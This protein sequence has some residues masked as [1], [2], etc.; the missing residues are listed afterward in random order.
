MNPTS[1]LLWQP[2]HAFKAHSNLSHFNNWL[3]ENK[4]MHFENYD[5]LWRWSVDSPETFWN[6][7][8]EYFG[9]GWQIADEHVISDDEMPFVNWFGGMD[10]NYAERVFSNRNQSSPALISIKEDGERTELTWQEL[11]AKVGVFQKWLIDQGVQPGDRVAAYMPNTWE[12]TVAFLATCA[13]GG[14][15][16]S[17][18][19][20]FGTPSVVERFSQV[21]P[22]VMLVCNAYRYNGKILDRN[23]EI[24]AIV[25][26]LGSVEKVVQ[27]AYLKEVACNPDFTTWDEVMSG[28]DFKPFFQALS[29]DHPIWVLYSSGTTGK[30][31]S[32]VHS[33]GGVLLEHLKYLA[34]HND[35]KSGERFIWY[36]TT[37]WM[38]WNYLNATLLLGAT[39]VLYD[40]SPSFPDLKRLWQLV[41]REKINHFGTSAGFLMACM[42]S[43]L[44]P[45]R[46]FD[47]GALR[48]IGSTGS[49][50]SPECFEWV[51]NDVKQ[52]VWLTSISGGTD[53]CSAFVGGNPWLPVYE[54]QIQCRAL[55]CK[56]EAW[57]EEGSAV[58]NEV[59]EM[60]ITKAMPSMPL[61]FWGDKEYRNYISSYFDMYPGVWRHGDWIKLTPEGGIVIYGRSDSTL[62]R[63]GVRIGSSEIYRALNAVEGVKDSL[64]VCIDHKDGSQFMPLFVV[65][66]NRLTEKLKT[67]IK[68]VL[69]QQYS[70]RHVPDLI[71]EVSQIPY[72]IS[73][74]KMEKPIKRI[75]SGEEVSKAINIGAM[76]NPES[77]EEYV[78]LKAEIISA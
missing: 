50:L 66:E 78:N 43:G 74:K 27:I 7:L 26:A 9:L 60:V 76:R 67:E 70:P 65:T 39:A 15:W 69:R 71:V 33:Q 75:L 51:Y 47:L 29:F 49:P 8:Q 56:L 55:G 17:C 24:Q 32:I 20:D 1:K 35:V 12:T 23:P 64:V 42:N 30:P 34:F 28:P 16:T 77:V 31:K 3:A 45:A 61:R 72:T 46:E 68:T 10:V 59:G 4:G 62:N 6:Y 53:V 11:E 73:G 5:Y 18:S 58:R 41:E 38:M 52:D 19:P 13:L 57:N 22:K 63:G 54:G 2:G 36:T 25:E 21:E 44:K 40:G 14:V 37:G 48:S